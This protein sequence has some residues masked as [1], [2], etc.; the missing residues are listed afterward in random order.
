MEPM[1]AFTAKVRTER[2]VFLAAAAR[3]VLTPRAGA[4]RQMAAIFLKCLE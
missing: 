2:V 4:M 3:T 1:P